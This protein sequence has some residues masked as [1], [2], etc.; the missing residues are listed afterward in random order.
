MT[1][2]V[3]PCPTIV[4]K[5]LENGFPIAESL[6]SIIF[7]NMLIGLYWFWIF[8]RSQRFKLFSNCIICTCFPG[9]ICGFIDPLI[10]NSLGCHV[11]HILCLLLCSF[12]AIRANSPAEKLRWINAVS[13]TIFYGLFVSDA[14]HMMEETSA[15]FCCLIND[16]ITN[17]RTLQDRRRFYIYRFILYQDGFNQ[18]KS[19]GNTRSVVGA[20]MLPVSLNQYNL[21]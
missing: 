19:L 21:R 7:C 5:K 15:F 12:V 18:K 16:Y 11:E 2:V 20:Y 10:N 4:I 14:S 17:K 3:I 13:F 1:A 6:R 9:D 8:R